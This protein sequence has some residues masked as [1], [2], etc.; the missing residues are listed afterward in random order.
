[1]Q[2]NFNRDEEMYEAMAELYKLTQENSLRHVSQISIN[3]GIVNT[4]A[5]LSRVC[6][7]DGAAR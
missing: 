2:L 7:I 4:L 6:I 5:T 3:L 1:M